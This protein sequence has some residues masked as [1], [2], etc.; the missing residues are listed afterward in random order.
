MLPIIDEV[1]FSSRSRTP[2]LGDSIVW[3]NMQGNIA[4]TR[5]ESIKDDTRGDDFDEL[6]FSYT[7]FE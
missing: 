6:T 3:V 4:I 7:I 2:E 1:E 5:I